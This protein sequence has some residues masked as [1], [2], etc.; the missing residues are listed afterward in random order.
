MTKPESQLK[1][2]GR[3]AAAMLA[4]MIGLLVM[5]IVN[6]ATV[7]SSDFSTFVFNVGKAWVPSAAGIGPYSGKET[8]LL[9]GWLG[10]W[11]LL[12]FALGKRNVEMKIAAIVF[13][14][15]LA[16]SALLVYTPFIHFILGR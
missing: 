15:G 14:V 5:G 6:T 8:F 7:A 3:A 10:S 13:I 11:I 16:I 1:P 9:I 2:N 4:G 12:H